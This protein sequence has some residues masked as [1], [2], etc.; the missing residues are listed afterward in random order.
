MFNS[1]IVFPKPKNIDDLQRQLRS[2]KAELNKMDLRK[3]VSVAII[4]DQAFQPLVNLQNNQFNLKHFTDI[5][6]IK[7]IADYQIVLCDLQGVGK[8]LDPDNQGAHLIKEIK[9]N[10]PEKYVV[11]YTGGASNSALARL[12]NEYADAYIKKDADISTWLEKLD[13]AIAHVTDPVVVWKNF[14]NRLLGEHNLSLLEVVSIESAYVKSCLDRDVSNPEDV[15][16]KALK[17]S[18]SASIKKPIE[19]FIGSPVFKISIQ[20]AR[21]YLGH[22]IND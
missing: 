18:S 21:I 15:M 2:K 9:S 12:G 14:R 17:G 19:E 3:K 5:N 6:D 4:D 22:H 20:L 8:L 13:T 16:R 1:F 11:A 7:T 10:Y